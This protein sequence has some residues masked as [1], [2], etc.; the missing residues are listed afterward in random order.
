MSFATAVNCMDGRVQAPVNEY[1]SERFGV[2]YVDE[3]TEAGP[4]GV[5]AADPECDDALA[6]YRKIDIS[7]EKHDS[8]G[9]A[10]VAHHD[11]AGNP[12]PEED[13]LEDL[14]ESAKILRARY[15]GLPVIT[16]WVGKE[17]TVTEP[18]LADPHP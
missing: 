14:A 16:L 13:Q 1:L 6:I 7:V 2:T 11:C 8:V 15:P 18:D 3:I 17:G 4:A 9:I 10:V 5:L 12:K